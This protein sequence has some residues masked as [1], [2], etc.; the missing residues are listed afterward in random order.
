[1]KESSKFPA[2]DASLAR[3]RAWYEARQ[4]AHA[5]TARELSALRTRSFVEQEIT[6]CAEASCEAPHASM[7]RGNAASHARSRITQEVAHG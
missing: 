6:R 7:A 5:S 3:A 4:V 1:M 2:V